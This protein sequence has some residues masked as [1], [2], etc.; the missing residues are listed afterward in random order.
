MLFEYKEGK[1]LEIPIGEHM[2]VTPPMPKKADVLFHE[3]KP[4]N[5]Y[6]VRQTDLPQE[7][8]LYDPEITE[9][10]AKDTF[11]DN[12][13][14]KTLSIADTEKLKFYK[15]REVTRMKDGVW[16]FNNGE[17]TYLTGDHYF[18]LQWG[19]MLGAVNETEKDSNYG[20]YFEFQRNFAYFIK[21]AETTTY[22]NGGIMTKSKKTGI[23]QFMVGVCFNR[24]ILY[25]QKTVSMMSTTA[26]DCKDGNFMMARFILQKLP[27]ILTPS[28]T[29]TNEGEILWGA[30]PNEV[31][32]NKIRMDIEYYNTRLNVVPTST[33]GFDRQTRLVAWVDE[34]TKIEKNTNPQELL[35]NSLPTVLDSKR[36]AGFIMWTAYVGEKNNRPFKESKQIWNDSSLKTVNEKTGKTASGL[37][38][39]FMSVNEGLRD[40]CDIYGKPIQEKIEKIIND[41]LEQHKNNQAKLQAV[42]RQYP[43]TETDS[44]DENNLGTRIFDN[45]RL[46]LRLKELKDSLATVPQYNDFDI[47]WSKTPI[48]E[49]H[50]ETYKFFKPYIKWTTD[51]DKINGGGEGLFKWYNREWTPPEFLSKYLY[52]ENKDK[53]GKLKP[54]IDSP[55]VMAIDPQSYADKSD[56]NHFSQNAIQVL[57]LPN[58]ELNAQIGFDCT[59]KRLM[60]EYL[61]RPDT[62]KEFLYTVI[63]AI[64]TF[65]CPVLVEHNQVWLSRKLIE[66]GFGNFLLY[67]NKDTKVL[68]PYNPYNPQLIP[69]NVVRNAKDSTI[70]TLVR[71]AKI[72]YDTPEVET[73]TD[74][75]KY[76]NSISVIEQFMMFDPLDTTKFDAAM[77]HMEAIYAANSIMG[78]RWREIESKKKRSNQGFVDAMGLLCM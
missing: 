23:S 54:A 38:K 17:P 72:Q 9:I 46:S 37:I 28:M 32:S 10:N 15:E 73:E 33:D 69:F 7:F 1:R 70:D 52:K 71:E 11:I 19:A 6:W 64:M 48:I 75:V 67:V 20:Q 66:Y 2:F 31:R 53:D 55:F 8:Y 49:E 47:N 57:I 68:E 44:W 76:L 34:Y 42:K 29:K 62:A 50:T 36:K 61:F 4:K 35:L 51:Y 77:C 78:T 26:D 18:N 25:K 14:L 30:P 59:N 40:G 27:K 63:K 45:I 41:D 3:K 39:W 43:R 12:G 56:V 22:A 74:N 58:V 24:S 65:N 13:V 16:F 5:Q 60:V 21:I